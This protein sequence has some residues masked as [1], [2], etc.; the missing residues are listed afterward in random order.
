MNAA[1]RSE[2]KAEG[3][4]EGIATSILRFL[5][6]RGIT[7]SPDQ[8]QEILRCA[9]LDRLDRWLDRAALATTADE[10]LQS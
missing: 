3:R 2:G 8:R 6:K 10:V 1:A 5:E 4:V 7:V 9:D